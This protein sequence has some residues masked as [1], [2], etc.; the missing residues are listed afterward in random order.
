VVLQGLMSKAQVFSCVWTEHVVASVG[1]ECLRNIAGLVKLEGYL[2]G[3]ILNL[4]FE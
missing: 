4:I 2:F 1:S 3:R